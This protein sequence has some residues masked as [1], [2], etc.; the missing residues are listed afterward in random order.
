LVFEKVVLSGQTSL[1]IT[2]TI[3]DPGDKI[4]PD[5][6]TVYN[7][8]TT[9]EYEG[10]IEIEIDYG[11][12]AFENEEGLSMLHYEDGEWLNVT[13]TL[14]TEN[15]II[16]GEVQ[17]LSPFVIVEDS[18]PPVLFGVPAD[19]TVECSAD[20]PVNPEVTATDNV[21][22]NVAVEFTEVRLD[23]DCINDYLITKT[24]TASD[25][26]GNTISQSQVITISD[27]T[28]PAI[29]TPADVTIECNNPTDPGIT[30]MASAIDNCSVNVSI[31]H[32]DV[33]VA[34]CGNTGVITRTWTATDE[35]GNSA[36]SVQI[37]T[38]VDTT[39][40]IL[41]NLI[42]P[43]DP[44]PMGT[45]VSISVNCQDENLTTSMI[46][47]GDG[48]QSTGYINGI[49]ITGDHV[50]AAPGVFVLK[51]SAM[52]ACG[53]EATIIHEYIVIYDPDGGFVTGGGWIFSPEGAYK[54]DPLL[55]GKASFGFVSKYKKGSTIPEGNTEFQFK[56]GNLNF[57]STDYDWLVIAGSK[58]MFKGSGTING[59]GNY[60]F[61]LSAIDAD[62]T[63]SAVIDKFRIKIWDK[64]NND[65]VVYDNNLVVDDNADPTT[66]IGG[67]SIIIHTSKN[68][69]A[70]IEP[71]SISETEIINISVYPNPFTE[72]LR[73][74]F[75]YPD[76]TQAL[77]DIYDLSGRKIETVFNNKIKGGIKYSAEFKSKTE[78]STMF[79][80][81]IKLG[82]EIFYD[83]VIYIKK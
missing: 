37:I 56:A 14:D 78:V 4:F 59:L 20:A 6:P 42:V 74:E 71:G 55:T 76:D 48:F 57:K 77:I 11:D 65:Y 52:D 53:E 3:E 13:K 18:E 67:G 81:R 31:S 64:D 17:S 50:F 43:V 28:P 22:G 26:F 63:P 30:G 72:N 1:E 34:G 61:M 35:C 9:A 54:P 7:I 24:W 46:D 83:N 75:E 36:T 25:N 19:I 82:E 51:V 47:W 41:S 44:V 27:N 29:T 33:F 21:A 69:S 15:N 58:A 73:F 12:E 68:K 23:G 32:E 62:L 66:E 40:P 70:I 38:I 39:P 8:E 45:S 5:D 16:K 79:F 10:P 49:Q 60:G 2:K 80:Y